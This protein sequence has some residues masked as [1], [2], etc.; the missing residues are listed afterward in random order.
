MLNR[1]ESFT[2]L[3]DRLKIQERAQQD[4]LDETQV[5]HGE[6]AVKQVLNKIVSKCK[7]DF[8]LYGDKNLSPVIL[9]ISSYHESLTILKNSKVKIKLLTEV[10]T[11]NLKY[12]LHNKKM[13][14]Q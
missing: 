4:D 3:N 9:E 8:L 6:E 10:T 2:K 14:C 13:I 12:F 11:D 1:Y 5:I 7:S